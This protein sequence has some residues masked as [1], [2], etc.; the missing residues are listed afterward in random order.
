MVSELVSEIAAC[1]LCADRF[2]ATKTAHRPR[3]VPWFDPRAR[4]LIAGQAPGARVHDSGRPFDDASGDRLRDWMGV[5][6]AAFY[7]RSAVAV[8]PMA[9]CYLMSEKSMDYSVTFG[10]QHQLRRSIGQK[11]VDL[12]YRS[13]SGQCDPWRVNFVTI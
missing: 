13:V 1:R 8:V 10:L 6:R 7:D 11:R 12:K 3:P 2:A 9:F 4:V 5:D